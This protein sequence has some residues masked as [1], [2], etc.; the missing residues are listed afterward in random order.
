MASNKGRKRKAR[1]AV[2]AISAH[3][4]TEGKQ[5]ELQDLRARSQTPY[6]RTHWRKRISLYARIKA[7]ESD[8]ASIGQP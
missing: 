7:L 8:I 5:M 3:T 6:M 1:E 2:A 4:R